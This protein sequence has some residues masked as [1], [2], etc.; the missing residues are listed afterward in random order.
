MEWTAIAVG[1]SLLFLSY[2][3]EIFLSQHLGGHLALPSMMMTCCSDEL[4]LIALENAKMVILYM[5][6][7]DT[8]VQAHLNAFQDKLR[9][10]LLC[11]LFL[12]SYPLVGCR[13]SV[14]YTC[15]SL[16][17]WPRSHMYRLAK[18]DGISMFLRTVVFRGINLMSM[19]PLNS[20]NFTVSYKLMDED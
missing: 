18:Q 15:I 17:N 8:R 6:G 4:H 14:S 10:H 7:Q 2:R 5:D 9:E 16:V 20:S 1:C 19:S 13:M 11:S 3:E 12:L